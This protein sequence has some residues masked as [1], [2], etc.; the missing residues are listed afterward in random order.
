[1]HRF[2]GGIVGL[3]LL[4]TPVFAADPIDDRQAWLDQALGAIEAGN[5]DQLQAQLD[6]TLGDDMHGDVMLAVTPLKQ[7]MGDH[8]A[9]YVDL[10]ETKAL[11]ES[12]E[13]HTYA[14]YYGDRE[15]MFYSF[16]FAKMDGGWHIYGL[17]Y[18]DELETVL[19]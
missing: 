17:D 11:G 15:F 18:N 7:A 19:N 16:V 2:L 3:A 14:A 12:F 6:E 9:E 10:L 8:A 5:L 4:A 1:M 13:M